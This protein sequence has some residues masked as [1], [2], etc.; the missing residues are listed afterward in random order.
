MILPCPYGK[1][2]SL[3]VPYSEYPAPMVFYKMQ[4]AGILQG[5]PENVDISNK[6]EFIT[7][8][9]EG[10]IKAFEAKY[11]GRLTAKF[12]HV[13][14]SFGRMIAKIGYGNVL[15]S[16]NP[17]DFS[18]VCLPYILGEKKNISFIVGASNDVGTSDSDLGYFLRTVCI[19]SLDR[20][21]I[22]CE[23]KL[24]ANRHTPKYHVVVGEVI[25]REKTQNVMDK[26]GPGELKILQMPGLAPLAVNQLPESQGT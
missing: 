10:K 25:G 26:L 9:D 15:C 1:G 20:F 2:P 8:V 17:G 23:V 16:L 3:K 6:W 7:I 18:P 4:Q 12:K 13:P 19:G 11:P 22:I 21:L 5:I 24:V 14:E